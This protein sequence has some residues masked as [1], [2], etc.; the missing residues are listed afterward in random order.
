MRL[1]VGGDGTYVAKRRLL[2]DGDRCF[3]AAWRPR[4]SVTSPDAV[5]A[6]LDSGAFSDAPE[7]RLT[8]AQALDRQLLF[9]KRASKLWGRELGLPDLQ[10]RAHALVSYDRLI[11]ETWV[12]GNESRLLQT[13][14]A[15]LVGVRR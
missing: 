13:P 10:W 11:D 15:A 14:E 9:E 5:C 3:T 12:A 4:S 6:L 7:D 8:P 2:L 1:F